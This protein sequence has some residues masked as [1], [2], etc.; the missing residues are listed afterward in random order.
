[1]FVTVIC[2]LKK[3][4]R[5][6]HSCSVKNPTYGNSKV[7]YIILNDNFLIIFFFLYKHYISF[8]FLMSSH[9]SWPVFLSGFI[10]HNAASPFLNEEEMKKINALR[11]AAHSLTD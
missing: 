7:I 4:L 9:Y 5:T 6:F 1:M 2:N 11:E 3:E 10:V 8:Y